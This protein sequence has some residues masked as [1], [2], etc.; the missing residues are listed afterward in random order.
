M[1]LTAKSYTCIGG[2]VLY[3][4]SSLNSS[5]ESGEVV[6]VL[7]VHMSSMAEAVLSLDRKVDSLVD[8]LYSNDGKNGHHK[9]VLNEGMLKLGLAD[10]ASYLVAY[11]NAE[12]SKDYLSV[13]AY[14]LAADDLGYYAGLG[15]LL[16]QVPLN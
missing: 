16:V 7:R 13:S 15:I 8:I 10:N 4:Y 1:S 2:R 6:D 5:C 3:E 9:L 12:L 11:V 14:A